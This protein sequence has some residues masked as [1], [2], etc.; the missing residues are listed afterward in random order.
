MMIY[1][2]DSYGGITQND[3]V[4]NNKK[5]SE[6]F[7]PAQP[8]ATFFRTIQNT[9]DC[10]DSGHVPFGANQIIEKTYTHIF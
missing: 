1:V 10:A 7:D 2:Y 3:L 9:V 8:I 6:P 5:L 4:E